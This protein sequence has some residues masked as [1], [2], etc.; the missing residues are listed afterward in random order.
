MA[1]SAS[2]LDLGLLKPS[3]VGGLHLIAFYS[4]AAA[5]RTPAEGSDLPVALTEFF[6]GTS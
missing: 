3:V 6:A 1:I 5:M 4:V 2:N